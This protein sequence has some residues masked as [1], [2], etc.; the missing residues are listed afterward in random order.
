MPEY[1]HNGDTTIRLGKV[2]PRMVSGE[3]SLD[4]AVLLCGVLSLE[5]NPTPN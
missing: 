1:M 2:M 4:M 3:K 5:C